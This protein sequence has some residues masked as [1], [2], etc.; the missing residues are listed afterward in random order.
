M[1]LNV[2]PSI[3]FLSSRALDPKFAGVL[4]DR[5]VWFL[6]STP[7]VHQLESCRTVSE[8]WYLCSLNG[9]VTEVLVWFENHLPARVVKYDRESAQ[10]LRP[11]GPC[12]VRGGEDA[13]SILGKLR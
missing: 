7:A 2:N 11:D 1:G 8:F 6:S 4:A 10:H 9:W 12:Q 13:G 5:P 3:L